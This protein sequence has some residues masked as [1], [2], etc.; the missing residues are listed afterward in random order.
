MKSGFTKT[1]EETLAEYAPFYETTCPRCGRPARRVTDTMD[2][3]TCSSW[4]YLRYADPHNDVFCLWLS[5]VRGVCAATVNV[6]LCALRSFV[7][8][9][10]DHQPQR[11][12]R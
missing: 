11:L 6:R 4:Y 10:S 1:I 7:V 12:E 2:T 8:D 3:F 5:D 9:V